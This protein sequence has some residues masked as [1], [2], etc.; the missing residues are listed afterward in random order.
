MSF[1]YYPVLVLYPVCSPRFL[2][3]ATGTYSCK[4]AKW[5]D[6]KLI[7]LSVNDLTIND[8]FLFADERHEMEINEHDLLVWYDV[9]SLFTTVTVPVDETI[10]GITGK[11]L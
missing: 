10:E 4:L 9:S 6:E 3:T 1:W 7:P 8:I 5:L 11:S 2:L